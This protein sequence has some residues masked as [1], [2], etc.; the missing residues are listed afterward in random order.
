MYAAVYKADGRAYL[1]AVDLLAVNA[2]VAVCTCAAVF[3]LREPAAAPEMNTIINIAVFGIDFKSFH[4]LSKVARVVLAVFYLREPMAPRVCGI[5]QIARAGWLRRTRL[6]CRLCR[7]AR[8]HVAFHHVQKALPALV[9]RAVR[10]IFA[11]EVLMLLHV[12]NIPLA[13]GEQLC[14]ILCGV[15]FGLIETRTARERI[16]NL[17][18]NTMCIAIALPCSKRTSVQRDTNDD[19][20]VIDRRVKRR[21]AVVAN[22]I[23]DFIRGR[24]IVRRVVDDNVLHVL[25]AGLHRNFQIVFALAQKIFADWY[26]LF[27]L[28]F[29]FLAFL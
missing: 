27:I 20:L 21:R 9:E 19:L 11:V 15:L 13:L 28:L 14:D 7:C 1:Y 3:D 6:G 5:R 2:C 16:A 17:D 25:S 23:R 22:H 18:M 24:S 29:I 4:R 10:A 8:R 26:H 12:R